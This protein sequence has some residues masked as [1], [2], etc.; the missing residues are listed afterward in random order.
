VAKPPTS[1]PPLGDVELAA[2]DFLW[3]T[4]AGTLHD[5]HAVVGKA[6]QISPNTVGSALERLFKKGLLTRQK[7]SHSYRYEPTLD[8]Q[9]FQA[10]KVLEAA[11][12]LRSL[13]KSGV[14][15]AFVDLVASSDSDALEELERLV[16]CKK[17]EGQ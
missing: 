15:A 8:R 11:G 2:L 14:L 4:G 16:Q 13:R 6:R 1:L 12:G 5:V 10:R 3:E 9:T 7:I 17:R